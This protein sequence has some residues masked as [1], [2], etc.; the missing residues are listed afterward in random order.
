MRSR[1]SRS[2]T[3][4]VPKASRFNFACKTLLERQ[5][6]LLPLLEQLTLLED[7]YT[8]LEGKR[9]LRGADS[10]KCVS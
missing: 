8:L 4:E 3:E 5:L 2:K 6:L 7:T 1:A 9:L 10:F